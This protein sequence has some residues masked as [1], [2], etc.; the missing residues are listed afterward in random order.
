MVNTSHCNALETVHDNLS[1]PLYAFAA[2]VCSL[3]LRHVLQRGKSRVLCV[4][5]TSTK[6]AAVISEC[7]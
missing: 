5:I 2:S 3:C 7:T 6:A 4:S 1:Q